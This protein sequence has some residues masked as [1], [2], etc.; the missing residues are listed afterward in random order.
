MDLNV[1]LNLKRIP[2][3]KGDGCPTPD[4]LFQHPREL[5]S[6][7][8]AAGDATSREDPG[9]DV[10]P[11]GRKRKDDELENDPE[12]PKKR[13]RAN[14][15]GEDIEKASPNLSQPVPKED[16]LKKPTHGQ[17][18]SLTRSIS[19]PTLAKKKD[20]TQAGNPG[21]E[22]P[23]H[24][25][26]ALAS[27]Q[28]K[29]TPENHSAKSAT[30]NPG[31]GSTPGPAR[32]PIKVE[33]LNPRKVSSQPAKFE[34]RMKLLKLVHT[35]I[36]RLNSDLKKSEN[37]YSSLSITK[38]GSENGAT[39]GPNGSSSKENTSLALSNQ[40]TV[41]MALDEEEKAALE[42]PEI[43][44]TAMRNV[45]MKYKR[46]TADKWWDLCKE[47]RSTEKPAWVPAKGAKEIV[48]GLTPTQEIFILNRLLTPIDNLS[49]HGYVS[50]IPKEEDI[51]KARAAA[52]T[53]QGWEKCC[54]CERRFQVFP[55]RREEDGALTS[56][57]VCV[58]HPG[59]IYFQERQPGDKSKQLRRYRCCNEVV[60]DSAGCTRG[61]THVFK[62]TDANMLASVTNFAETPAND[63]PHQYPVC[64]DCEMGFTV[65]GLEMIRVTATS[66]PSGEVLL[67]VLVRPKGEIL[68]LNSR[69]SGIWPED[70]VEAESYSGLDPSNPPLP[71]KPTPSEDTTTKHKYKIVDSPEA[72]RQLFFSLISP[73]TPLIGH[74]L[75]N[76]LNALRVI[77]P[78]LV[79]TVLLFP[80]R[81]G[82]PYRMGLKI[83]ADRHLDLKIQV[84]DPGSIRGHDSAEDAR[85]AGA[86]ARLKV[87][88]EWDRMKLD[89]WSVVRGEIISP[90]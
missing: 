19:P 58:H 76:D 72:A 85:A 14:D 26:K 66:W 38:A 88:E 75:E 61:N 10:N 33:S 20:A 1:L 11:N 67:D 63:N 51:K 49:K 31:S 39:G 13:T 60:G 47:K 4:C 45:Y 55:G 83:L 23:G 30:S 69:Y 50:S 89:G 82:L 3:P 77:H 28:S 9:H 12:P 81:Q 68:D 52:E 22:K 5:A 35:E 44:T 64:F 41:T 70:M 71:T 25:P 80:H 2:C 87:K 29:P 32:K 7:V 65:Y 37:S 54:R 43:Y 17:P 36:A 42:K 79:D 78:T 62:V 74:G 84:E 6:A 34:T 46:M 73:E 53:A 18:E 27:P 57:G 16:I 24:N 90:P 15:A 56:G 40:E 59:K 86:L 21:Q 48:T 8:P